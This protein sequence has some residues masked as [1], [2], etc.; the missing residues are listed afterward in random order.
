MKFREYLEKDISESKTKEKSDMYQRGYDN[1][2]IRFA[3]IPD[4]KND[5]EREDFMWGMSDA[6]NDKKTK[7]INK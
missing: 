5:K 7:G 2:A 4:F 3:Y 1:V 6:Y